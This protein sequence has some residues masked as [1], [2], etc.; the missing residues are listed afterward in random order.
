VLSNG[1]YLICL[2]LKTKKMIK[3][4]HLI[5]SLLV[6]SASTFAQQSEVAPT[7][8]TYASATERA[9]WTIQ[10]DANP[11]SIALGLAGTLW[12]GTEF[13]VSKWENDSIFT[14]NAAGAVTGSFT[15][16][17]IT[18]A[19]SITTDGTSLYM[20]TAASNIY[21]V[22]P[23]TKTLMSTILTSV[24]ACRYLTYDPTL[25]AGAGGFWTGA[26]GSDITAVS[27]SGN[28]LSTIAAS[29]HGLAG[30]Y[31]MAYDPY[32]AG[33]P[34]LWAYDQDAVSGATLVQLTIAGVMTGL[35]HDT[36]ADLA[37]GVGGGLAGGLF[38][39]NS[40]VS[41][42]KTIGGMNQGLSLFAYELSDPLGVNSIDKNKFE[43]SVFPNPSVDAATVNF[44]LTAEE[45]VTVEVYNIVGSLVSTIESGNRTVGTHSIKIDN[46]TLSNG[47]YF[48]KLTV[49]NTVVA[50]K[51]NVIK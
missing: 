26:Y 8:S 1:I 4:L 33:G 9:L 31:G 24:P 39:T 43:L 45:M 23:V 35:T 41:G 36:N 12:T 34:Y 48:V 50:S 51:F 3:K 32:S 42:Q 16:A 15:I 29:T 46:S 17:G 49:G 18:A 37:G 2:T 5:M 19:R 7:P 11:T 14:A 40:F 13:W 20:G 47:S 21:Q 30:I 44:K 25:N 27:M 10:L 38:I 22:N 28:T 6:V